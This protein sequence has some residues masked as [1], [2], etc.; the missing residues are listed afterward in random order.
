MNFQE[1]CL[2]LVNACFSL[3]CKLKDELVNVLFP[4]SQ[5]VE[6]SVMSQK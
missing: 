4:V 2:L 3:N 5:L 6:A 1:F